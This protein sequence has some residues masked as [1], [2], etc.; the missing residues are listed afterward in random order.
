[1]RVTSKLLF[2]NIFYFCDNQ[3]L[4]YFF[5]NHSMSVN[6]NQSYLSMKAFLSQKGD[7]SADDIFELKIHSFSDT[8]GKRQH[9]SL[10]TVF[11]PEFFYRA[12]DKLSPW[13]AAP[14]CASLEQKLLGAAE[15]VV[16]INTT[17]DFLSCLEYILHPSHSLSLGQKQCHLFLNKIFVENNFL[18]PPVPNKILKIGLNNAHLYLMEK[19]YFILYFI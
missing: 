10:F 12:S 11:A 4:R 2:S 6:K 14:I 5:P 15:N 7:L 18:K 19:F 16:G 9:E 13:N 1:M 17:R 3:C 8:D